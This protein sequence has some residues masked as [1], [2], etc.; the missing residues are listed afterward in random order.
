MNPSLSL[1]LLTLYPVAYWT[2]LGRALVTQIQH[3]PSSNELPS[4]AWPTLENDIIN[5]LVTKI[6][7]PYHYSPLS[8]SPWNTPS[9]LDL[10]ALH[11]ASCAFSLGPPLALSL[12]SQFNAERLTRHSINDALVFIFLSQSCLLAPWWQWSQPATTCLHIYLFTV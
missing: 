8:Y 7:N 4:S 2:S 6:K 5:Y 1:K 9:L 12:K 10:E 3:I 11:D